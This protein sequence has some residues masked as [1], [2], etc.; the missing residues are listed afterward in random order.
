MTAK[1]ILYIFRY[2][3][4]LFFCWMG[5]YFTCTLKMNAHDM[6]KERIYCIR[7]IY[8]YRVC[9][10]YM[11][12]WVDCVRI[13]RLRRVISAFGLLEIYLNDFILFVLFSTF[14]YIG[15]AFS[16]WTTM[17]YLFLK[18]Q[19]LLQHISKL[20]HSNWCEN[21]AQIY[22]FLFSCSFSSEFIFFC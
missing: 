18:L 12:W 20:Y 14:A 6:Q 4:F 5:G 17:K 15:S 13:F 11:G 19:I 21:I 7:C 9:V 1:H 2:F 22:C 3:L 8:I 16:S 10:L